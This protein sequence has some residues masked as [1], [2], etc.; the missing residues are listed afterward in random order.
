MGLGQMLA[1]W[2]AVI[3]NE[4]DFGPEF[5]AALTEHRVKIVDEVERLQRLLGEA[6][7]AAQER[8][9]LIIKLRATEAIQ[10][11]VVADGVA[12]YIRKESVLDGPFCT[13]CFQQNHEIAR[14]VS[15]PKPRGADGDPA[16]WVQCTKCRTPFRSERIGQYLS[17]REPAAPAPAAENAEAKSSPAA[18]K[19]RSRTRPSKDRQTEPM[20]APVRRKVVPSDTA[21]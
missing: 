13:T 6:R 7:K 18:R 21:A 15:A 2:I 5:R 10:S 3:K 11:T 19:P 20:R 16:E 8:D 9:E 4:L 14:V 12:Y 1:G 17:A